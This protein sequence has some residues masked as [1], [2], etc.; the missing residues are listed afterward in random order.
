M[1]R[2]A[3]EDSYLYWAV[4]DETAAAPAGIDYAADDEVA[5][6]PVH[7]VLFKES[8]YEFV[9]FKDV[10]F[11]LHHAAVRAFH[12][13]SSVRLRAHQQSKGAKK[14]GLSGTGLPGNNY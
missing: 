4:V 12:Y 14:D 8:A 5:V 2:Q 1:G 9:F 7:I 11:G 3:G 10:E 6:L 13:H